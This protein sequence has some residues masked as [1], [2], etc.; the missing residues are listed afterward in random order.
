MLNYLATN[1]NTSI[2]A[3]QVIT[4]ELYQRYISFLDASPKTVATY[5]RALKQFINY[6]ATQGINQPT[7]DD[8]IAYR[9]ALKADH[10]PSTVQSYIVAVRL[11]FQWTEQEGLYPNIAEHVKGAK[12]QREHKKDYLTASQLKAILANMDT[13]TPQ[14]RRNFAIFV[15]TVSCGLRTIEVAR[16]DIA[17]LRTLGADTV[18]Y[19]QGK[20]RQEK[21][22]F[23]KI[24]PAIEQAIR[25]TLADRES[26]DGSQP[27]FISLSNNS[28]GKR[29][30]TRSISGAIKKAMQQ[31]GYDSDR[32]TAHSLRHSAVTL[33]LLNG[34]PLEEVQAFA[35]HSNIN[36]TMIYSHAI[37]LASNKCSNAVADAIL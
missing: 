31:A 8:V 34:Q 27:L 18:L 6:L 2:Q 14:G 12:I 35:R 36:T 10:K 4:E 23:V 7:R 26:K 22:D 33:A 21:A 11:F 19:L 24:P 15:L 1:A 13:D 30:T 5:T 28:L 16:A 25:A 17:D 3:Q 29:M 37:D 9:E 32:L 20:G